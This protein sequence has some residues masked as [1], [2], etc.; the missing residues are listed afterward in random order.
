[1]DGIYLLN[2][3]RV[4]TT[5]RGDGKILKPDRPVTPPDACFREGSPT[6]QVYQTYSDH[7][8]WGRVTYYFNNDGNSPMTAAQ[9]NLQSEAGKGTYVVYNWYSREL[10]LLAG[11][12]LLAPGYEGHIYATVTPIVSG[13]AFIGEV[14]KYTVA[15]AL[16]FSKIGASV[17]VLSADVVG[18]KGEK[19]K[20]CA[21]EGKGLTLVCKDIEFNQDGTQAVSFGQ[22]DVTMMI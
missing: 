13:W 9:V 2:A 18:V 7:K 15:S 16:R 12:N 5:C 6:C 17:G 21:V 10:S 1:M 8:S 4:M 22:A 20:V 14:D 19:V 11:S 3:S